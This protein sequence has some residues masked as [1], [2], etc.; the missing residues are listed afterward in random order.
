MLTFSTICALQLNL[1][2]KDYL[3]YPTSTMVY[4]RRLG[5][6]QENVLPMHTICSLRPTTL[7]NR[8]DRYLARIKSLKHCTNCTEKTRRHMIERLT[9]LLTRPRGFFLYIGRDEAR[10]VRIKLQDMIASCSIRLLQGSSTRNVPCDGMVNVTMYVHP[11]F[12]NCYQIMLLSCTE[13]FQGIIFFL[14]I[15]QIQ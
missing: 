2:L 6:F 13:E 14:Y 4:N 5:L 1:L 8:S 3:S 15:C 10:K 7:S 11:S 9:S 12:F